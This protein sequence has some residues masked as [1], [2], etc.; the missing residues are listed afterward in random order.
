MN[1]ENTYFRS[2]DQVYS[3]SGFLP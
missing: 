2:A 1:N 3:V